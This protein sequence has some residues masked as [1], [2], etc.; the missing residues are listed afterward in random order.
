[1]LLVVLGCNQQSVQKEHSEAR[2]RIDVPLRIAV[3]VGTDIPERLPLLWSRVSEQPVQIQTY[4]AGELAAAASQADVL[5]LWERW[6]GEAT[7]QGHIVALPDAFAKEFNQSN[8][9]LRYL[10]EYQTHW[11]KNCQGISLGS[12]VLSLVTAESQQDGMETWEAWGKIAESAAAKA[13]KPMAAEPLADGWAAVMFLCRAAV[14]R[15]KVW[16]FDA[17]SLHPSLELPEYVETLEQMI[18]ARAS[19]PETLLTPESIWSQVSEGKLVM[20]VTYPLANSQAPVSFA[21]LPKGRFLL[22]GHG[23]IAAIS[24]GCRQTNAARG[25]IKWMAGPDGILGNSTAIGSAMNSVPSEDRSSGYADYDRILTRTLQE[26]GETVPFLR[27]VRADDYMR[28]LDAAVLKALSGELKAS[29]SL[30]EAS[31]EWQRLNEEIGVQRQ[32]KAWLNSQGLSAT[33]PL[34]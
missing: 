15:P 4:E 14:Q 11:Q 17:D 33:D 27:I 24:K 28:S 9:T 23:Q 6:L 8:Q 19:Y 12:P 21:P 16:L 13:G 26:T 32:Q 29:E 3:P 20:G 30:K 22:T 18:K 7:L 34:P 2:H 5:I 1:M 25:L 10:A 31:L